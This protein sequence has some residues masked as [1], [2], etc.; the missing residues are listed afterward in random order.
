MGTDVKDG[1]KGFPDGKDNSGLEND[2]MK[3]S[4]L[5]HDT[6][7]SSYWDGRAIYRS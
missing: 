5:D 1:M 6:E 7:L 2:A 3:A 4:L